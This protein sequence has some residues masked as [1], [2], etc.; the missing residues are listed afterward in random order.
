M[1]VNAHTSVLVV[2]D[3]V[4]LGK[5]I[6]DL[7][8]RADFSVEWHKDIPALTKESAARHALVLL[9]LNLPS[10]SGM[11]L[12]RTLRA[13]VDV[14]VLVVTARADVIDRVRALQLGADDYVTKPFWPEELLERVRARLR[15]P[16]LARNDVIER[17]ALRVDLA[18]HQVFVDGREV[19]L[20]P[21]EH[22][23]LVALAK[24]PDAAVTRESLAE[25][26]LDEE[27]EDVRGTLDA[28]VSRLRKK[29]GAECVQTVWGVGY[30]L[31]TTAGAP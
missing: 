5:Q 4:K 19:R 9:D 2:E 8:T 22:S 6:V 24:R 26:A 11:D 7:L 20:T 17:G 12:L 30:R 1:G 21:A 14:P 15:R 29:L 25:V 18:R 3:D 28:H 13:D 16:T 31:G 23:I 10:G 27:T